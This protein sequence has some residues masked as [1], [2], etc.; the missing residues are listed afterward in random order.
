[1]KALAVPYMLCFYDL[2]HILQSFLTNSGFMQCNIGRYV[3]MH[4][5]IISFKPIFQTT[6]HLVWCFCFENKKLTIRIRGWATVLT[7]TCTRVVTQRR[8]KPHSTVAMSSA[9]AHTILV[10]VLRTYSS[11]SLLSQG[12]HCHALLIY[13][14]LKLPALKLHLSSHKLTHSLLASH[15]NVCVAAADELRHY[16]LCHL[17]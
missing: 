14:Q 4:V 9:V 16:G 12:A 15:V 1:M 2:F 8:G 10:A 3:C 17:Q 5:H 6:L 13:T 11:T 7:A